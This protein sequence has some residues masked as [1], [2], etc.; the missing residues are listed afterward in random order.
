MLFTVPQFSLRVGETITRV[1]PHKPVAKPC[2]D[3]SHGH[4][5]LTSSKKAVHLFYSN[6]TCLLC[7]G[8]LLATLLW[9]NPPCQQLT[10]LTSLIP[11]PS[12]AP[13]RKRVRYT[14]SNFWVSMCTEIVKHDAIVISS[15]RIASWS[16][17]RS[18]HAPR[19][20]ATLMSHDILSNLIGLH[21][22]RTC[23]LSTTISQTLF[24][25]GAH[26]GLGKRLW[27]DL[28]ERGST[29]GSHMP[30]AK[31]SWCATG[32]REGRKRGAAQ[33]RQWCKRVHSDIHGKKTSITVNLWPLGHHS[34]FLSLERRKIAQ[35]H[36]TLSLYLAS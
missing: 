7:D 13:A 3:E 22:F 6:I 28:Q 20:T 29:P 26:E 33:T 2:W 14:K 5:C 17:H 25:A 31:S 36:I 1:S 10:G 32:K 35:V 21:V 12:H 9:P 30:V 27:L 11:R 19:E 24:C 4:K 34:F 18:V 16:L 15:Y 23:W 8:C